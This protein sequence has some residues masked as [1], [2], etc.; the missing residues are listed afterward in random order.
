MPTPQE[1]IL[2]FPEFETT[3]EARIQLFLDDA[4]LI[5]TSRWGAL[6]KLGTLYLTAHYLA[7]SKI[8]DTGSTSSPKSTASK[9]VEGVSISYA[10]DAQED[11]RHSFYTT[12][13]YGKRY[14]ELLKKVRIGAGSTLV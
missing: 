14:L 3:P 10:S 2:R 7:V 6:Q 12:T 4:S 1:F 5:V 13:S 9:S 8:T 11:A